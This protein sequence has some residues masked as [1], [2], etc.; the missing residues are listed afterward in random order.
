MKR[1]S[2]Q[3][4][5]VSRTILQCLIGGYHL[6]ETASPK[7]SLKAQE[8]PFRK[9]EEVIGAKEPVLCGLNMRNPL[10]PRLMNRCMYLRYRKYS[11]A[12]ESTDRTSPLKQ[13]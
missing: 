1:P 5:Q 7:E 13:E 4:N 6:L 12:H 3:A 10:L 8:Y 9:Q 11:C 2:R